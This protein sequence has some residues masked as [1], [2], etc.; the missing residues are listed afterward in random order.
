MDHLQQ[1]SEVVHPPTTDSPGEPNYAARLAKVEA[2]VDDLDNYL[3]LDLGGAVP[4]TIR[5]AVEERVARYRDAVEESAEAA[6][7]VA[8]QE[9]VNAT[10]HKFS[11][12]DEEIHMMRS[13][14]KTLRAEALELRQRDHRWMSECLQLRAEQEALRGQL[15]MVC[16]LHTTSAVLVMTHALVLARAIPRRHCREH[17]RHRRTPVYAKAPIRPAEHPAA[18]APDLGRAL[19]ATS[20][21]PAACVQ[22]GDEA[23]R[24]G[25]EGQPPPPCGDPRRLSLQEDPGTAAAGP[26]RP[27][28]AERIHGRSEDLCERF[29]APHDCSVPPA[30]HV[31]TRVFLTEVW[32]LAQAIPINRSDYYALI[33]ICVLC[34]YYFLSLSFP[35]S[36]SCKSR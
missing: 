4:D 27:R 3:R 17:A 30:G 14:L 29:F 36:P 21:A 10:Q 20:C 15:T 1:L 24:D 35:S 13:Q 31:L 28:R 33:C 2:Q 12:M 26:A 34:L 7:A 18:A 23:R 6:A 19:R 8:A 22:R 16:L 9:A 32:F 25:V 11:E 5:N